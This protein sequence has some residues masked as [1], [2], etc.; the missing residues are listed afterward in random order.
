M[1]GGNYNSVEV[2]LFHS[3]VLTFCYS[4]IQWYQHRIAENVKESGQDTKSRETEY[5]NVGGSNVDNSENITGWNPGVYFKIENSNGKRTIII[6]LTR[7]ST[8]QNGNS[9]DMGLQLQKNLDL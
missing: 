1:Y 8:T 2:Y 6:Q 7:R 3:E 9:T 4:R 5:I